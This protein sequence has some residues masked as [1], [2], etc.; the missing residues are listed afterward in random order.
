MNLFDIEKVTDSDEL[1]EILTD[2]KNIRIERII[3]AGHISPQGFWYD[4]D[5]NEFVALLQGEA[6]ITFEDGRIKLKAGDTL[7][8][9]AH[10]KHRVDYTT[11]EPLCIWLCVFY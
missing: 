1:I 4:Q 7:I 2:N 9:P 6:I 3:S 10:K 8:I 5:E 11:S